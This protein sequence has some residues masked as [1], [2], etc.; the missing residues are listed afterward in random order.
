MKLNYDQFVKKYF[1]VQQITNLKE[2]S[3]L[4]FVSKQGQIIKEQNFT[5]NEWLLWREHFRQEI[6][7]QNIL[8]EYEPNYFLKILDWAEEFQ[9]Q[10]HKVLIIYENQKDSQ[11]LEL[12]IKNNTISQEKLINIII[13]I[14]GIGMALQRRKIFHLNITPKNL[15]YVN[16][17]I[18]LTD[19]VLFL[20]IF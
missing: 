6:E 2:S 12:Y 13:Q 9:E 1:P 8:N 14:L 10:L 3:S 15:I 5:E 20:K 7:L 19:F 18:K 16:G 4:I 17:F 11:N